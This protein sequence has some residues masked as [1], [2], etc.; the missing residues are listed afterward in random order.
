MDSQYNTHGFQVC[1]HLGDSINA[2]TR[3]LH[4]KLNKAIL[5]HFPLALPPH[6][7]NPFIYATGLLHIAPIYLTF[8]SLWQDLIDTHSDVSPNPVTEPSPLVT[9][10]PQPEDNANP[11]SSTT[12]NRPPCEP[13]VLALLQALHHPLL[14]RT[15]P[16]LNDLRTIANQQNPTTSTTANLLT[17]LAALSSQRQQSRQLNGNSQQTTHQSSQQTSE[18]PNTHHQNTPHPNTKP[19]THQHQT[20]FLSRIRQS[21][22]ARPHV[23]LAYAWVFYMALFSGGRVLRGLLEGVAEDG[24]WDGFDVN[25]DGEGG[26]CGY[27]V[28]GGSGDGVGGSGEGSAEGGSAEAGRVS[29]AGSGSETKKRG[30]PLGFFRFE[31]ARDGE[32]LKVEF[33]ERF[34]EAGRVLTDEERDEVVREAGAIFEDMI[35]LVE[36]LDCML[37]KEK[38]SNRPRVGKRSGKTVVV[39]GEVERRTGW[40]DAEP[41]PGFGAWYLVAGAL[42][43]GVGLWARYAWR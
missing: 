34:G 36:E 28:E 39:D 27:G 25:G 40:K 37:G 43:A 31:T 7:T 20:A 3:T 21:V 2:A 42:L 4:A 22:H 19:N 30:L 8:E 33:K 17:E 10:S 35:L 14:D 11:P 38:S 1:P 12:P 9:S 13:R 26:G 15:T 41:A 23:L 24:F 29:E 6:T 32:D 16:L 18:R 5:Q